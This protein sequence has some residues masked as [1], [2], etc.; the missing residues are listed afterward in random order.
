[1]GLFSV[2]SLSE[3]NNRVDESLR[4][5]TTLIDAIDSART[6]QVDFK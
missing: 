2:Y 3:A 5:S 4:L 1:L 6:A